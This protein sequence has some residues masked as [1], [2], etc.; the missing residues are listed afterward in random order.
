M[1]NLLTYFAFIAAVI[2]T[3][4]SSDSELLVLEPADGYDGT[5]AV[6]PQVAFDDM[7]RSSL[8]LVSGSMK[9]SWENGDQIAVYAVPTDETSFHE[10]ELSPLK[11]LT[12]LDGTAVDY[13]GSMIGDFG[14]D[15]KKLVLNTEG[16][17]NYV[18][19][20]PYLEA[21]SEDP[22]YAALLARRPPEVGYLNIPVTYDGQRQTANA[23]LGYYV[24][25]NKASLA[26]YQESEAE[27]SKHLGKFDYLYSAAKQYDSGYTRFDFN[28]LQA[29]VRFFIQIPDADTPQVFDSLM[30]FNAFDGNS[31]YRFTTKGSFNLSTM[32][33]TPSKQPNMI[34]LLLGPDKE[35][36]LDLVDHRETI[37]VNEQEVENPD[38]GKYHSD[39][40]HPTRKQY[41]LVAYLQ[42]APVDLTPADVVE[43]TLYL[44]GH[45]GTGQDKV[46]KY[47]KASLTKKKLQAG[48]AYQWSTE[49]DEEDPII[50]ET[51]SVQQWEKETG[52][53]NGNNGNGTQNW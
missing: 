47:Y 11:V 52:Y 23:K 34:T 13:D 26:V 39:Y 10:P 44:C 21:D 30:V 46:S 40:L 19:W 18:A 43:P 32:E 3:A 37:T 6:I 17:S 22:D 45:V 4:C 50:L 31:L 24:T 9:F 38:Y 1:K 15:G 27:A 25:T 2:F 42:V 51:I 29:T 48:K 7:S 14:I 41:M 16:T 36:G 35:T 49:L 8:V 53:N 5:R 33:F 12:Y 20:S 28:H